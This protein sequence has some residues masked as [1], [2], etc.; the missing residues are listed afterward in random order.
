MRVVCLS[1]CL[2]ELMWLPSINNYKR[3]GWGG[4]SKSD[5]TGSWE[6]ERERERDLGQVKAA[7]PVYPS[8]STDHTRPRLYQA[9]PPDLAII[10]W[11]QWAAQLQIQHGLIFSRKTFTS[12]GYFMSSIAQTEIRLIG[13]NNYNYGSKAKHIFYIISYRKCIL[14]WH[15]SLHCIVS[16]PVLY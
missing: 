8:V 2:L 5:L 13:I 6:T 11:P 9:A 3:N 15:V 14:H 7:H 16:Y 12:E 1:I 4:S 10:I